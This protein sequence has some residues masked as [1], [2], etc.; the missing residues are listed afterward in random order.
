MPF[1]QL[2]PHAFMAGSVRCYAPVAPGVYG[3]SNAREWIYI[4]QAENIQ[5][6]LLGHLRGDAAVLQWEPTGFVFETCAGDQRRIRQD[7]LVLEYTPVC[8]RG[9]QRRNQSALRR[10]Q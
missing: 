2:I 1:E 9:L 4:G 7:C 10:R 6:A 3:I 5:D 8:S